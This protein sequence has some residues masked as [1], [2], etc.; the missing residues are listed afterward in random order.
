MF[1]TVGE[2]AKILGV[3]ASTLRY[4]DQE[5]LLPFVGRSS[6]GMRMFTEKDYE[7]LM[8]IGCL[9]R[10][11]LSIRDI[12][13]F[14]ALAAQGDRSISQRLQLFQ[15]RRD[16]LKRQMEEQRAMLEL[17]EYKCWYYETAQAAGTEAA[18]RDLPPEKIPAAHR[19][20]KARLAI[21]KETAP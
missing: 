11:G 4:Y 12:K 18:V 13:A 5:G 15:N 2:M 21:R 17:L 6:G 19:G 10:S 8:V 1:Y 7:T 20:A 14:M 9:K 3:P 16:A